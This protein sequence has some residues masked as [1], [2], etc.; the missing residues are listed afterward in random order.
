MAASKKSDSGHTGPQSGFLPVVDTG[1]EVSPDSPQETAI[2]E[3][4]GAESGAVDARNGL[5]D[6]ALV[7]LVEAWPTLPQTVR[8]EIAALVLRATNNI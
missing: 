8:D 6:P 3:T 4:G 7:S 1:L 2:S 5:N